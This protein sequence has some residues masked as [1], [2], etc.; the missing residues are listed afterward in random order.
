MC[1]LGAAREVADPVRDA[2]VGQLELAQRRQLGEVL[3]RREAHV[4][5][6]EHLQGGEAVGKALDVCAAAVVQNELGDLREE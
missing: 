6:A 2:V 3:E 4:D 5:Q 1:Q